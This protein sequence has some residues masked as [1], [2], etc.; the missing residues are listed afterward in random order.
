MAP[1]SVIGEVL[2]TAGFVDEFFLPFAIACSVAIIFKDEGFDAAL[3][4]DIVAY[5]AKF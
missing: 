4:A 2:N 1:S 3:Q 5:F